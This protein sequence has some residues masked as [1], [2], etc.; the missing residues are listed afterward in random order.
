MKYLCKEDA[1]N[2]VKLEIE[3]YKKALTLYPQIIEVVK[4]FDGKILNKRF[5]T[6]LKK[7]DD[8][9][10]TDMTYDTLYIKFSAWNNRSIKSVEERNGYANWLY[11]E[12][13]DIYMNGYLRRVSYNKDDIVCTTENRLIASV[14]I[15]ALE[16]QEQYIKS[17]IENLEKHI[18]N[19]DEYK[20][21]LEALR[22]EI[23]SIG[24]DI[25]SE[26]KA[27]FDLN[28]DVTIR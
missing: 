21:K 11:I 13:T 15:E 10:R 23:E 12:H 18:E 17:K 22:K 16:K 26:I 25:P 6:A 19:T 9:L 1:T 3:N 4:S 28:Y 14:V 5:E 2:L 24:K 20:A 8:N 7:V 27:Y